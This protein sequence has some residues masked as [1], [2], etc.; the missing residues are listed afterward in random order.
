MPNYCSN[1]LVLSHEDSAKLQ[2]FCDAFNNN[3]TCHHFCPLPEFF[4]SGSTKEQILNRISVQIDTWGTK[5]D[6]GEDDSDDQAEVKNNTVQVFF[7]T[8]WS[9]PTGLYK[10]LEELGF[11]VNAAYYE[12]GE[13]LCGL[14]VEGYDHRIDYQDQSEIPLTIVELFNLEDLEDNND[15]DN[16]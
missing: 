11:Q 7:S 1:H 12:P 14:F 9:P 2:E 10:K 16:A 15:T 6:F 13:K 8:A 3:W 4:D 5:W